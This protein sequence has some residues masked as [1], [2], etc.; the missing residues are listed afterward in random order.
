VALDQLMAGK[1]GSGFVAGDLDGTDV[2]ASK[3]CGK[4]L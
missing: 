2:H 4:Q 3:V 1:G